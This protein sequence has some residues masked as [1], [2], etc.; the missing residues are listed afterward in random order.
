[1]RSKLGLVRSKR[2]RGVSLLEVMIAVFVTA[3]GVLGAAAM[4]L[5]ALKYTDSS[6][7]SSQASF[8][9]YDVIDRIRANADPVQ[10]DQYDIANIEAVPGS[11]NSV[12]ATDLIDFANAVSALPDGAGSIDV[13]GSQVS[14]E[15]SWSE[16]RAGGLDAEG[17]V[18][19]GELAITTNVAVNAVG[20][21]P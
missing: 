17:N 5:N 9:V 1:M 12:L 19:R 2:Q 10:L 7:L 13:N 14:V 11:A 20:A 15:V 4:Q 21:A 18:Q 16:G 8:I 6:R 3:I